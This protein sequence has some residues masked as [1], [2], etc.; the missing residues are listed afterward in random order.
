MYLILISVPHCQEQVAGPDVHLNGSYL[1]SQQEHQKQAQH[2]RQGLQAPPTCHAYTK[3]PYVIS[4]AFSDLGNKSRKK[5]E[6]SCLSFKIFRVKPSFLEGK[7]MS[8]TLMTFTYCWKK[9]K[10][11]HNQ[12]YL[13]LGIWVQN[14]ILTLIYSVTWNKKMY[15]HT[16]K[17]AVMHSLYLQQLSTH[18]SWKKMGF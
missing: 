1:S 10:I 17:S 2:I 14:S 6:F 9:K 7:K 12:C 15:T 13:D 8:F 11:S 3:S 5:I 16:N 4:R 18:S